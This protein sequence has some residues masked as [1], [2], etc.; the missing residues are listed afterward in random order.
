ML[1]DLRSGISDLRSSGQANTWVCAST[2]WLAGG[3]GIAQDEAKA[4][5]IAHDPAL[6]QKV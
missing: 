2:L 5:A 4:N 6:A 1:L 3:G